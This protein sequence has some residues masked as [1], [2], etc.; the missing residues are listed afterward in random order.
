MSRFEDFRS[1]RFGSSRFRLRGF[2]EAAF[3][4]GPP[5]ITTSVSPRLD[6]LTDGE[7]V[8]SALSADALDAAN[9]SSTEGTITD[10]SETVT[11]NDT[12][13]ALADVVAFDDV[14]SVSITVSDAA[15]NTRDF[16]A[17][18]Q[19]VQGIAP[20]LA[21]GD[22]LS[23]RTLTITVDSTTGVPAPD[24]VLTTLTLD[25]ADVLGDVTGAG[26]WTYEVPDSADGQ[27]VAWTV[28]ASNVAGS[29]TASGSEG[30][31]ANLFAPAITA[32]PEITGTS[33]PGETIQIVSATA[34]GTPTPTVSDTLA[35]GS[36][37][38]TASIDGSG[39]YLIPPETTLGTELTLSSVASNGIAPDAQDSV[40]VTVQE[41]SS[42][43]LLDAYPG[44]TSAYSFRQLSSATTSVVRVRRSSDN[45]EADFTAD[46]VADGTL[47][48][49]VGAGDGLIV[50][51]FDQSGNGR[52]ATQLTA[53]RQPPVVQAGVLAMANGKPAFKGL[54][55]K[56]M[57]M[58][59]L[60]NADIS[61]GFMVGSIPASNDLLLGMIHNNNSVNT[62]LYFGSQGSGNSETSRRVGSPTY[63]VNGA[64]QSWSNRGQVYSALNPDYLLSFQGINYPDD[65]RPLNQIG[66][67]DGRG[68]L[69]ETI[70]EVI[71]YPDDQSANRSAIE[72]DI[73]AHYGMTL[74]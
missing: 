64:L 70:N 23:G 42:G 74:G 8:Q 49:W 38:V 66:E 7:T 71:I 33:A 16:N 26:P 39:N 32:A 45:T 62:M 59:D 6:T 54:P 56:A 53:A 48:S 11:I 25:G 27:T 21:A 36:S 12:A 47:V 31:A 24:T 29:D 40:S 17:G 63:Y 3:I 4:G 15:G 60:L 69:T 22:S 5:V 52:D 58:P 35:L 18:T 20:T 43:F 30:V 57:R 55:F 67:D 68:W 37:D 73:A 34:S 46:E 1:S 65:T 28:Q 41:A 2:R 72:Q 19:T 61:D 44:A 10:V 9:Y 13:G 14:V 50:R 51:L